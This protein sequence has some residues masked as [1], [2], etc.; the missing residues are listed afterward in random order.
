[1]GALPTTAMRH[2]INRL[3]L[4][5]VIVNNFVWQEPV[6]LHMV[7]GVCTTGALQNKYLTRKQLQQ[8]S[9]GRTWAPLRYSCWFVTSLGCF[10]CAPVGPLMACPMG[11]PCELRWPMVEAQL[12]SWGA[13]HNCRLWPVSGDVLVIEVA[14]SCTI[15]R[16][17][18]QQVSTA[19]QIGLIW[20]K[21]R[22][23]SAVSF[24]AFA[25]AEFSKFLLANGSQ[26]LLVNHPAD[27]S[28]PCR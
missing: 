15:A 18:R 28:V 20:M 10:W 26:A 4:L 27:G 17:I 25:S 24:A 6:R 2:F 16:V 12:A 5:G 19:Q 11:W 21:H 14:H 3:G 9:T 8:I 1:M 23:P 13:V 7:L 22:P